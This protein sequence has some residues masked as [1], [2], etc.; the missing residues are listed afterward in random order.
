MTRQHLAVLHEWNKFDTLVKGEI[1]NDIMV[2]MG[3]GRA[4]EDVTP[5]GFRLR[6]KC[7]EVPQIYIPNLGSL[8]N[9]L[10]ILGGTRLGS[11]RNLW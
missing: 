3:A 7:A 1:A 8:S 10:K 5:N 4:Q 2:F 11:G 9:A 6:Y